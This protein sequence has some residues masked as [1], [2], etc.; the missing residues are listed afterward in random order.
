[1]TTGR[2]WRETLAKAQKSWGRLSRILS[3]E[4]ADKRLSGDLFKAV[5]QGVLLFRK[6]TWVLTP[7]MEQ[8]LEIFMHG[9]THRITGKQPRRGGGGK[10]KYPPVKEAM[11]EEG[12]EGIRK[13]VTRRQNTVTQYIATQ[14]ILDLCERATQR[15]G[16][17][18][19]RR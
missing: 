10:W 6:E 9:A 14:P 7:R 15:V 5:V 12:F 4:G 18:V 17:R 16:A 19:S 2:R 8:E 1:M 13:A 11:R 3:R